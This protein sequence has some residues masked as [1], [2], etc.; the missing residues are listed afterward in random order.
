M[1]PSTVRV[2]SIDGMHS[3]QK[4]IET[5][6][7]VRGRA[8]MI[9]HQ[10][11][12]PVNKLLLHVQTKLPRGPLAAVG[13]RLHPIVRRDAIQEEEHNVFFIVGGEIP[14]AL[15]FLR[16]LDEQIVV[17]QI[18]FVTIVNAVSVIGTSAVMQLIWG[19][20]RLRCV[21]SERKS[22]QT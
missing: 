17:R 9:R 21:N 15:Q 5:F 2:S 20:L 4:R 6:D 16:C 12:V 3:M 22:L 18:A 11:T 13:N 8:T 14:K 19:R 7:G 10:R 1:T